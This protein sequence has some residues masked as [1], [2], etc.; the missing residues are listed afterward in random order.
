VA[1]IPA[2]IPAVENLL[3]RAIEAETEKCR[4]GWSRE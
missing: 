4:S 2:T 3:N 1:R